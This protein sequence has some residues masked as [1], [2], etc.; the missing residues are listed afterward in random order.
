M[1]ELRSNSTFPR[2]F[3]MSYRSEAKERFT[4]L[5]HSKEYS[6]ARRDFNN[7]VRQRQTAENNLAGK[8]KKKRSVKSNVD[9][10]GSSTDSEGTS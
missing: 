5:K 7:V 3:S 2:G 6:D 8:K 10:S 4:R 1:G 9:T